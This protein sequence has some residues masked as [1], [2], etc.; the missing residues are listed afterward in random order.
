MAADRPRLER[1]VEEHARQL[2]ARGGVVEVGRGDQSIRGGMQSGA[3]P[4]VTVAERVHRDAAD[5][6]E[7]APPVTV[8]QMNAFAT[9]ELHRCALVGRRENIGGDGLV[10]RGLHKWCGGGGHEAPLMKVPRLESAIVWMSPMRT[11]GPPLLAARIA[12]SSLARIP[13]DADPSSSI[14]RA[15]S[16]S[17]SLTTAPFRITPATST[18]S[19]SSSAPTSTAM[20]AAA[21]SP[22]TLRAALAD[23]QTARDRGEIT[24]TK[25]AA[26][27]VLRNSV[28]IRQGVPTC[29]RRSLSIGRASINEPS[30]PDNPTAFT[31][32]SESAATSLLFETPDKAMRTMSMSASVVTLRPSTN[33]GTIP[34]ARCNALISSPPP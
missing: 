25:P 1:T 9:D 32:L 20:A 10:G 29:P 19:R 18:M 27:S 23:P 33:D 31:P 15:P 26:R 3:K 34:K 28:L 30:S 17:S 13:A 7:V 24:G 21:S 6:V 11:R 14:C 22:L 2:R 12:A 16:A 5:E 8:D 4:C